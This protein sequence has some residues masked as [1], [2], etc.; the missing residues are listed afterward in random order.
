MYRISGVM[1][2]NDKRRNVHCVIHCVILLLWSDDDDAV[3]GD[4]V[5]ALLL[6]CFQK[7]MGW[8]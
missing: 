4:E 3:E 1:R 2:I 6:F 5:D 8:R 7:G